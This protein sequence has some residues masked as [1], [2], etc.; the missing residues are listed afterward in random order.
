MA[1][2]KQALIAEVK[3]IFRKEPKLK[4][5][6]ERVNH[7]VDDSDFIVD[8][9]YEEW[10]EADYGAPGDFHKSPCLVRCSLV[11]QPGA[12]VRKNYGYL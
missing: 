12:V 5:Y 7:S 2:N 6:L 9:D 8:D 3:E 10:I 4:E 11:N 1:G